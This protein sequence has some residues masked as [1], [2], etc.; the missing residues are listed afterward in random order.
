MTT[1]AIRLFDIVGALVLLAICALPMA[2][3]AVAIRG[4]DG[5]PAM[6]RQVRVGRGGSVFSIY[7]FRSMRVDTSGIGSGA[8]G[9]NVETLAQA[10]ARFQRTVPGDPRITPVGRWLR[11]SHLDELPQL[12]NILRGDMSFVGVRPDTPVQEADYEPSFWRVRHRFRPGLTGPAQLRT[13]PMTFD[14]RNAEDLAWIEG[15]GVGLYVRILA[16]TA[17]K[18]VKRSSF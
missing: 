18:V 3:I 8:V 15:Y 5:G 7:K 2:V 16:A 13:D 12:L 14:Q 11:P 6:F 10:N 9:G 4:Y 17:L 1:A